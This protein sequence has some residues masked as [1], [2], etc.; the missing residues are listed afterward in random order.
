MDDSVIIQVVVMIVT[1]D[2]DIDM[3]QL[4][5]STWWLA[6]PL[7]TDPLN[8]RTAI[9]EDRI[10]QNIQPIK[11][12]EER[13]MSNPPIAFISITV[14]MARDLTTTWSHACF[15]LNS[16]GLK[17]VDVGILDLFPRRFFGC[18]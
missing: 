2:N 17:L 5:N 14:V 9:R 12:N 8:C 3:W 11:L 7:R 10:S 16:R 18:R 4:G 15:P 6:I 13:C 1:D